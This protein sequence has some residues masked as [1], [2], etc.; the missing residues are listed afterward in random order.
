MSG[1]VDPTRETFAAFR[2]ISRPGPLH[3]LNLVRLREKAAYPEGFDF[4][5][6]DWTGRD[7]YAEY[8]RLS[9][10]VF[11]RLGGRI[12]WRGAFEYML[13]GPREERWDLCFVAEYPNLEAFVEMI[14]NPD[15]R[16]AV[17]HRQA[18]VA[19]SRLI[20]TEPLD[21]GGRFSDR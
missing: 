1:H 5:G 12:V 19:D 3:M 14:K 17:K 21:L 9:E 10:P 20:R 4:G 8:G 18:A 15:Y 2:D 6:R 7:A 11:K 13:I 16:E